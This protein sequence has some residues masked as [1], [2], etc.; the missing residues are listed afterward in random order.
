MGAENQYIDIINAQIHAIN[1]GSAAVMNAVREES[2]AAFQ[3]F[4]IPSSKS[5]NYRHV[6][7]SDLYLPDYGLNL[8]RLN[9]SVTKDVFRCSVSGLNT[10]VVYIVGDIPYIPKTEPL[11]E[12]VIIG[13]LRE[14]AESH[15]KLIER[16]YAK[17]S[18]KSSDGTVALNTT[19]AQDGIILYIPK[20]TK[21]RRPLQIVNVVQSIVPVM[22]NRRLLVIAEN[23]A[24]ASI[25]ICDHNLSSIQTLSTQVTEIFAGE[26]STLQY[27][28]IEETSPFTARV[29]SLFANQ[30]SCSNLLIDTITLHNGISR[31][32]CEITLSGQ[33]SNIEFVGLG[34]GNKSQKIDNNTTILHHA[35]NC[36][37]NELFKYILDDQAVASF[38]G[39]IVVS[40][41]A[42]K[43]RSRQTNRNICIS[44][45][46]HVYTDPQL[47]IYADDVKCGHGATVG[48]LDESA[49]FYLRQR[50]I[51][52]NDAR[53]MLMLAFT[54][55]ITD[56]V[57][58]KP[59]KERLCQLMEHRLRGEIDKCSTCSM[60]K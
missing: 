47:E 48:Q 14:V 20:N 6:N 43:T 55:D 49:L 2:F 54:D 32:N 35:P 17:L 41:G 5:E 56:K 10:D 57:R 27:Y 30:E 13:S 11:P 1:R 36:E 39:R 29:S 59:L 60:C 31:N 4:G 53:M 23:G 7:L 38:R 45:D 16:Y 25:L 42:D 51:P 46:S 58:L 19:L 21:L 8:G 28:E 24:E 3:R 37:S 9:L 40:H 50:G 15:P 22:S 34:I 44:P 52:D 26:N 18:S 33:G 12:G